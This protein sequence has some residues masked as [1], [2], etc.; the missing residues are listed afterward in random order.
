VAERYGEGEARQPT[1]NANRGDNLSGPSPYEDSAE[2]KA[3]A[4]AEAAEAS[5]A[6][7]APE[8]VAG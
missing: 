8:E 4:E 1:P 2:L 5:T 3:A 7:A 6:D